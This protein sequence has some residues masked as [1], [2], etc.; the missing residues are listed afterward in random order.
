M[1]W[2][3]VGVGAGS[4]AT[5]L[6]AA[7]QQKKEAKKALN[8]MPAGLSEATAL[9]KAQANAS[10]YAGQ[11]I[12]EAN[13][14]QGTADTFSNLSKSTNNSGT[15]LNAASQ[16]SGQQNKGLQ[17]I[18]RTGQ[19]FKQ[20]A[21]DRYRQML[22]NVADVQQ[23][24]RSYSESLKGAAMRN[25]MGAANSLL[26]G[27]AIAGNRNFLEKNPGLMPSNN[28]DFYRKNPVDASMYLSGVQS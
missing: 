21:M 8:F 7:R 23:S 11:D 18:A 28:G 22:L 13:L 24:N 10:R 19:A 4:A 15:L 12:D 9:S 16:L 26:G 2:V 27:I 5:Q 6:L 14:R 20:S 3:A 17:Q 25:K 1:S